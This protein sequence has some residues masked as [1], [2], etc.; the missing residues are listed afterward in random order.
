MKGPLA[1][2]AFQGDIQVLHTHS[3]PQDERYCEIAIK[4]LAQ[5][6]LPLET[7]A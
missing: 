6:V 2:F 1:D 3:I 4:R 5:E 7:S